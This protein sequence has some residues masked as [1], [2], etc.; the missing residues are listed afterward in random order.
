MARREMPSRRFF[1]F[2]LLDLPG[3]VRGG[4]ASR[5][6]LFSGGSCRLCRQL[7]P[8]REN[9]WRAC[10]PPN[11]PVRRPRNSCKRMKV[12]TRLIFVRLHARIVGRAL[13]RHAAFTRA[14]PASALHPKPCGNSAREHTCLNKASQARANPSC[15]V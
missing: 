7:P 11:L 10:S 13:I 6:L 2:Q 1:V 15:L 12:S 4:F 5:D 8:E 3:G 14:E 9:S